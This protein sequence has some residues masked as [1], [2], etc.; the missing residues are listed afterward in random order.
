MLIVTDKMC[1]NCDSLDK[2]EIWSKSKSPS[3]ICAVLI[4]KREI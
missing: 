3:A 4:I 2:E 1:H